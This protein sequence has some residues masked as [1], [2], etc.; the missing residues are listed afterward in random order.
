MASY[1]IEVSATAEKQLRK[2]GKENRHRII[3]AISSL[4]KTPRP[5]GCRKLKGF[6]DVYRIRVGTYRLIY[7][8]NNKQVLIIILKVGHRKHVYR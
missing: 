3:E 1:K 2:L 8:I 6:E 4:A 5:T 7:N